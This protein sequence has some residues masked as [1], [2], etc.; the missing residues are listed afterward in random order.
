MVDK[1]ETSVAQLNIGL[2][3]PPK[4]SDLSFWVFVFKPACPDPGGRPAR[5]AAITHKWMVSDQHRRDPPFCSGSQSLQTRN[6]KSGQIDLLPER[7]CSIN[8]GALWQR[9][10]HLPSEI[11][12]FPSRCVSQSQGNVSSLYLESSGKWHH[13]EL[14]GLRASA[15]RGRLQSTSRTHRSEDAVPSVSTPRPV[16]R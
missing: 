10:P 3:H 1:K 11:F 5:N 9:L 6:V 13:R 7:E 2:C 14:S 8:S 4:S 12:A 16:S 15:R